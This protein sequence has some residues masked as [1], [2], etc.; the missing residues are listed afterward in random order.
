M[1]IKVEEAIE[2]IHSRLP[3]GSRPGLERVEALLE[4]VG[5]PQRKVPTI[6]VAGTNGK[7][8][9]VTYLRCLLEEAGLTVGTFTSPYIE[10]FNER[11]AIDGKGINNEELIHYVE[12]YRPL[13]EEMDTEDVVSGITEFETLTAMAFD[14]FLDKQV[15]V[16]IIEVGLGGLMDSTNVVE[17]MLTAITTI[18][19]DH[20]DIL[21]ETIE[22]I[23]FQKAGIIKEKIPVVTGNI[24]E[25]ALAVINKQ[26]KKMQAPIY[27]FNEDYGIDYLHFDKEWGEVFSFTGEAGKIEKLKTPLLGQH[28]TENAGVAVELFY[29]YCQLTGQPFQARTVR[30]GLLKA[31]WP[32]RMEKI[33]DEPMIVLDGAHNDHAVQRLADNLRKEF[34]GRSIHI[35]FSSLSTKNVDQ[36]IRLLKKVPNVQL[37]LTTFE[38]PKAVDLTK[39]EQY[40]DKKTTIV[41]LWQ[42]GLGEILEKMGSEDM[43]L[44]TG[45]LYFVS[46]VRELLLTVGGSNEEI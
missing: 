31:E 3:F 16:A 4:R 26:A 19:M 45:S 46:Q 20:T 43:L 44:V 25:E 34:K 1:S 15:D 40:A 2:W 18:G 38:Y 5:N 17:P 39:L 24:Q 35:L 42:F 41:S 12:K 32:A 22:E 8:S 11:I 33:S 23:A 36:M 6:H 9:T 28:Q 21:G 10:A 29:I 7:G 27:H 14:Y 37:Y 30:Q 13:V